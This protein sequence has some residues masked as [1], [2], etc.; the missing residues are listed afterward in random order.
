M[1]IEY[2]TAD[3]VQR[4]VVDQPTTF[5][6]SVLQGTVNAPYLTHRQLQ[7]DVSGNPVLDSRGRLVYEVT[8]S[9]FGV[10]TV[11]AG[12]T[13]Y[14]Y[15]AAM[16]NGKRSHIDRAIRAFRVHDDML[17]NTVQ[18]L[19]RNQGVLDSEYDRVYAVTHAF[20]YSTNIDP[21][22][23]GLYRAEDLLPRA[24]YN[25]M[26]TSRVKIRDTLNERFKLK[27]TDP[28]FAMSQAEAITFGEKVL[29][30]YGLDDIRLEGGNLSPTA[31]AS[32]Q[33]IDNNRNVMFG[34]NYKLR[35]GFSESLPICRGIILHEIAHAVEIR[36]FGGFGHGPM[37]V[38]MYCELLAKY[39][40]LNFAET[41]DH[42]VS[43][44][45]QVANAIYSDQFFTLPKK[46]RQLLIE[47]SRNQSLAFKG[48][49][50]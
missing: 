5:E 25:F 44:D 1:A 49:E 29:E 10:Y 13:N 19:L 21:Q 8:S 37:F 22:K 38:L 20:R 43:H 50:T 46:R 40:S 41:Y 34:R 14:V 16:G 39:T 33:V 23:D 48:V 45:L 15:L 4:E 3:I 35:I 12:K 30:D 26:Q 17:E 7:L 18:Q 11:K 31:A 2:K 27:E 32:C 42:F 9:Q 24:H 28:G 47:R 6:R 36:E